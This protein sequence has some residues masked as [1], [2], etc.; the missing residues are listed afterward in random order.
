[1]SHD[2]NRISTR[3]FL[4]TS[5][6]EKTGAG[7][8]QNYFIL[9]FVFDVRLALALVVQKSGLKRSKRGLNGDRVPYECH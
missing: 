1:V 4:S 2:E 8:K 3:F 6:M 7:K 5:R 9:F